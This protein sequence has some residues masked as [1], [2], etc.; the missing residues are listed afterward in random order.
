MDL[1]TEAA[2]TEGCLH[3]EREHQLSNLKVAAGLC[4]CRNE[5]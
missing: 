5:C 4:A 3:W 2:A 1:I